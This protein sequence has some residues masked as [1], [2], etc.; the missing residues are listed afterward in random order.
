MFADKPEGVLQQ[1]HEGLGE[2]GLL[3]IGSL[4]SSTNEGRF[5]KAREE[6]TFN[7]GV[8]PLSPGL[9]KVLVDVPG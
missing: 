9:E 3:P 1:R 2:G 5:D 7:K 8:D 4:F 6:V